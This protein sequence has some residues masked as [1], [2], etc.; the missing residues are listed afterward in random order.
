MV[1]C[2]MNFEQLINSE[3]IKTYFGKG[4]EKWRPELEKLIDKKSIQAKDIKDQQAQ[5]ELMTT[6]KFSW[7]GF[8][9]IY[10]WA[11]YHNAKGWLITVLMVSALIFV[12]VF[13]VD[14]AIPDLVYA[15]GPMALYAMYGKSYILAAKVDEINKT[16]ALNPLNAVQGWL[17]VLLSCAIIFSCDAITLMLAL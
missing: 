17:R 11:A 7:L 13:L 6:I 8:L 2:F 14:E 5:S 1:V 10:F 12:D 15:V 9:F 16:G 4:Y 3:D